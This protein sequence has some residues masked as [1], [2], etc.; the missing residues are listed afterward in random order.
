LKNNNKC[1][2][3]IICDTINLGRKNSTALIEIYAKIL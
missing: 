1:K 3:E 2:G